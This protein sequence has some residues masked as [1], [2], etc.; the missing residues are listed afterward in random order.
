MQPLHSKLNIFY[1]VGYIIDMNITMVNQIVTNI[2]V[3]EFVKH[4]A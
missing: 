2:T 3:V 1:I 4:K